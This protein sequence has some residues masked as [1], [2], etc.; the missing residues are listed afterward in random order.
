MT[1][2]LFLALM[3][4]TWTKNT[5]KGSAKVGLA[6][7]L[8][9][10]YDPSDS[11]CCVFQIMI[12]VLFL[13]VSFVLKE[14]VILPRRN[15]GNNDGSG[16]EILDAFQVLFNFRY[17]SG[18]HLPAVCGWLFDPC[19]D[20]LTV[21][22]VTQSMGVGVRGVRAE[23]RGAVRD[24]A[25]GPAAVRR[26]DGGGA[27]AVEAAVPAQA[28]HGARRQQ[29]PPAVLLLPQPHVGACAVLPSGTLFS[30]C[31]ACRYLNLSQ[32]ILQ[33]FNCHTVNLNPTPDGE[34]GQS[35][36][37]FTLHMLTPDSQAARCHSWSLRRTLTATQGRTRSC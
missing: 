32:R 24:R 22:C 31:H 25:G 30:C 37:G 17:E 5:S 18:L 11:T 13:Q 33:V 3:L 12:V 34:P 1:V 35:A 36:C 27:P 23:L 29:G 6:C 21:L 4:Y 19:M 2:V 8:S 26:P 7:W 16:L 20:S 10:A 14:S 15:N 28:G 9:P